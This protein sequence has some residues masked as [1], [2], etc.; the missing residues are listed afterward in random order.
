VQELATVVRKSFCTAPQAPKVKSS[1]T[2]CVTAWVSV[3]V[4]PCLLAYQSLG[5][6][7]CVS[8]L[9]GFCSCF[10]FPLLP[11][12][13]SPSNAR[14][15]LSRSALRPTLSVV[16]N[17]LVRSCTWPPSVLLP[18]AR[19]SGQGSGSKVTGRERVA[20]STRVGGLSL[21]SICQGLPRSAGAGPQ[22]TTR[23]HRPLSLVLPVSLCS[24][25][26]MQVGAGRFQ[27]HRPAFNSLPADLLNTEGS[28]AAGVNS[29]LAA[30]PALPLERRTPRPSLPADAE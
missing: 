24:L 18:D 8:V 1:N 6:N 10:C 19:H 17:P 26:T 30:I 16:A 21:W 28:P 23:D 13:S 27:D 22:V 5:T 2:S 7:A 4:Y 11:F 25:W 3:P 29:P 14:G 9:Q 12:T 20:P 15:L